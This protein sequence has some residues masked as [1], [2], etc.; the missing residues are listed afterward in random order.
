VSDV[1]DGHGTIGLVDGIDD[2]VN[3]GIVSKE[4]LAQFFIFGDD[5]AAIGKLLKAV[6][7][8]YQGVEPRRGLLG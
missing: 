7:G 6:N 8:F 4:E 1:K 2:F 3:V 5:V